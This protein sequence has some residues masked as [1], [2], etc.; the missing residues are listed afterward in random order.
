M[1]WCRSSGIRKGLGLSSIMKG[2]WGTVDAVWKVG[3]RQEAVVA[4]EPRGDRPITDLSTGKM[5]DRANVGVDDLSQANLFLRRKF[6]LS[7]A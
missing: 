7:K 6:V 4:W 3:G 1:Q 5:S 2:R